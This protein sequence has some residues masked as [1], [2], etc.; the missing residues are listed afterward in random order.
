MQ[1]E[2][3]DF[4]TEELKALCYD[5]LVQIEMSQANLKALNQEIK[6]RNTLPPVTS[7]VTASEPV[8]KN[9]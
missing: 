9:D 5:N 7:E 6:T 2:L 4:T 8:E 1:K 3:K